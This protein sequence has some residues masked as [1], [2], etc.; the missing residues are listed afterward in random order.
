MLLLTPQDGQQ[1]VITTAQEMCHSVVQRKLKTSEIDTTMVN[2]RLSGK[3]PFQCLIGFYHQSSL[4]SRLIFISLLYV[5][6][7]TRGFPDPELALVFGGVHSTL[8]FPPWQMRL[9]EIL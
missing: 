3:G 2:N 4:C 6:A 7:A 8:G 1:N 9:T 5:S